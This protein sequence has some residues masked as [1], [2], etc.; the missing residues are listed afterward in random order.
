MR[1]KVILGIAGK[2]GSGKSTVSHEFAEAMGWPYASFGNYVRH[3]ARQQGLNE[4]STEVLQ[5]IG[6]DL[7]ERDPKGF[8]RSV[9]EYANWQPDQSLI[10]DGIRHVEVTTALQQLTAPSKFV[11]TYVDVDENTRKD[12]LIRE[13]GVRP[14]QLERLEAHPTEAQVKSKLPQLAD[15]HLNANEPVEIL[16][17]EL[18]RIY[19]NTL[20]EIESA[21]GE[22]HVVEQGQRIYH[23]QLKHQ[24]EPEHNGHYVAIEPDS[25]RYFLG[26]TGTEALVAA[27][28]EM[29]NARFYLKRIGHTTA[30]NIGGYASRNR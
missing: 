28:S 21:N 26:D 7:V 29:P 2:M 24:L 10:I 18:R 4:G 11:L 23:E 20:R 22:D 3:V 27:H 5:E 25:G 15:Y 30:H 17:D 12:R 13:R 1:P 16:I 6:E 8:C 19:S 9:L 14:E